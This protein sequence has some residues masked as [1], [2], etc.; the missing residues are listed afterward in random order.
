MKQYLFLMVTALIFNI[1][2]LGAGNAQSPEARGILSPHEKSNCYR[3]NTQSGCPSRGKVGG[4]SYD[5]QDT[6]SSDFENSSQGGPFDSGYFFDS[7]SSSGIEDAPYLNTSP[8]H[9]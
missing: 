1:S 4:Y 8:Y 2:F 5:A 6:F 9:N 3:R 7:G